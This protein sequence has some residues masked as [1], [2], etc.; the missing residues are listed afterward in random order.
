MLRNTLAS[1][2]TQTAYNKPNGAQHPTNCTIIQTKPPHAE[3]AR[4]ITM[5]QVFTFLNMYILLDVILAILL[6][7]KVIFSLID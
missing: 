5:K 7:L 2:L 3:P 1:R 6:A 4:A